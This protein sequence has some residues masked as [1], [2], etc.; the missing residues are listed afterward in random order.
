MGVKSRRLIISEAKDFHTYVQK[1]VKGITSL[2][3]DK[4]NIMQRATTFAERWHNVLPIPQIQGCHHFRPYDQKCLVISKT[5][6]SKMVKV[7]VYLERLGTNK[8]RYSDV[9]SDSEEE[10]GLNEVNTGSL[11]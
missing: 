3:V 2:Y 8:L 7:N 6:K 5:S 1:N 11:C 9:Y 10:L 4:H